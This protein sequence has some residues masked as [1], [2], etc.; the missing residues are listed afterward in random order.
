MKR[1]GLCLFALLASLI[2]AGAAY[3]GGPSFA[4]TKKSRAS[5]E[6]LLLDRNGALAHYKKALAMQADVTSE[7]SVN[8]LRDGVAAALEVATFINQ[9]WQSATP[10]KCSVEEAQAHVASGMLLLNVLATMLYP[11][12]PHTAARIRTFLGLGPFASDTRMM[13]ASPIA[14]PLA[15]VFLFALPVGHVLPRT[16]AADDFILFKKITPALLEELK[17]LI[18]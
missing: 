17:A 3:A 9:Y 4:Q 13:Y 1:R 18:Y 16:R 2:L 14:H 6:A 7:A 11:F 12:I 15:L 8:A 10:W 5:S